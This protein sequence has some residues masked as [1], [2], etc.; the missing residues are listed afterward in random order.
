ML[1]I[2]KAYRPNYVSL[3]K[4]CFFFVFYPDIIFSILD[5]YYLN[6]SILID[7]LMCEICR[8]IHIVCHSCLENIFSILSIDH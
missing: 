3:H 2:G 1:N 5:H 4:V 7:F 8:K 6:A